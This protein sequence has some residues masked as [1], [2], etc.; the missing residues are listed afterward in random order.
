MCWWWSNTDQ[1]ASQG[2]HVASGLEVAWP[3]V[4]AISAVLARASGALTA[5]QEQRNSTTSC[6]SDATVICSSRRSMLSINI[7]C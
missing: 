4:V 7:R 1:A 3:R 6:A 2:I 5:E